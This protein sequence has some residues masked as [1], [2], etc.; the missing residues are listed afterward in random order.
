MSFRKFSETNEGNEANESKESAVETL[1]KPKN[2]I[3]ET[4]KDYKDD[5]DKKADT[6][7]KKVSAGDSGDSDDGD[8]EAKS[9]GKQGPFERLKSMFKKEAKEEPVEKDNNEATT[10]TSS[11]FRDSLKVVMS[12]EEIAKYNKEHGDPGVTMER[13][14]GGWERGESRSRWDAYE[15]DSADNKDSKNNHDS[16]L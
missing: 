14:K 9:E 7:E 10:S 1:D 15:D 4:P 6:A 5:F 3:L 16:Y 11:K 2:Q 8:R 13:P 12:P